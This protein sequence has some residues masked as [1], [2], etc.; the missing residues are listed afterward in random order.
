[1]PR[2][3][4]VIR[5]LGVRFFL[6][7]CSSFSAGR[8]RSGSSIHRL[9]PDVPLSTLTG[10]SRP[11]SNRSSELFD[12][13]CLFLSCLSSACSCLTPHS[14]NT[15]L[16][17]TGSP[18]CRLPPPPAGLGP[19]IDS[20]SRTLYSD[21]GLALIAAQVRPAA[22]GCHV[23]ALPMAD[24]ISPPGPRQLLSGQDSQRDNQPRSNN[25]GPSI[26][27][28]G[29]LGPCPARE[30]QRKLTRRFYRFLYF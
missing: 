11:G 17:H 1:M 2:R 23:V 9:L 22:V 6:R 18:H 15:Q 26:P 12:R 30:T 16:R 5:S 14:P 4:A 25:L 24:L 20:P 27:R 19:V 10:T 3:Q 29:R 21:S 8:L 7:F 13:L 28:L